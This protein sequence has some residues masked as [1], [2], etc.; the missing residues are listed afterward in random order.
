[1]ER[2]AVLGEVRDLQ[3]NRPTPILLCT[4]SGSSKTLYWPMTRLLKDASW[5][6]VRSRIVGQLFDSCPIEFRADEG[7]DLLTK[8]DQNPFL[9]AA[10]ALLKP[11][12][13]AGLRLFAFSL[14]TVM[15]SEIRRQHQTYWADITSESP[16][17]DVKTLV[18]YSPKDKVVKHATILKFVRT[19]GGL[20]CPVTAH[21]FTGDSHHV[22]HVVKEPGKY[23]E[24]CS[25]LF[26]S[27]GLTSKL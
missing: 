11:L 4:F 6:D 2:E 18:V 10:P 16:L 27:V 23:R 1:M 14:D 5:G 3:A 12:I 25:S 17:R 20:G 9:N 13:T 15:A 26:D 22:D 8:T 19:L 21:E 7:L 24:A